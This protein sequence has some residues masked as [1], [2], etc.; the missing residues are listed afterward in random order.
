M[1][2]VLLALLAGIV[3]SFVVLIVVFRTFGKRLGDMHRWISELAGRLEGFERDLAQLSDGLNKTRKRD[4]KIDKI[5]RQLAQIAGDINKE[6][7]TFEQRLQE[8]DGRLETLDKRQRAAPVSSAAISDEVAKN[9]ASVFSSPVAEEVLQLLKEGRTLQDV[10]RK[11][12]LQVGEVELIRA[13][14]FFAGRESGSRS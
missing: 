2:E 4:P 1:N 8:F 3:P 10:A 9:T 14:K 13:L 5:A 12:G 7:E 6:R 11:T